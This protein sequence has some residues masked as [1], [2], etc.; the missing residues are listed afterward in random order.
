MWIESLFFKA[1]T[2]NLIKIRSSFIGN[3]VVSGYTYDGI[4]GIIT[5]LVEGEGCFP[6]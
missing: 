5:G 3:D 4:V 6:W 2:L 1:E